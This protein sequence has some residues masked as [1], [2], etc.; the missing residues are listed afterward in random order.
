M[1]AKQLVQVALHVLVAENDGRT[2]AMADVNRLRAEFPCFSTLPVDELA[3]AV[4]HRLSDRTHRESE[5]PAD[6][7]NEVA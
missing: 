4:I 5:K 6:T 1:R 2:P 3:C 7:M